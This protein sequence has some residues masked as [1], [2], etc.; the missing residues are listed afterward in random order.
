MPPLCVNNR[1]EPGQKA[2]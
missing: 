2:A 1:V